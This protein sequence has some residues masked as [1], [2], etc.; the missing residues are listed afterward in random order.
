MQNSIAQD[1]S[2][3]LTNPLLQKSSLQYQAPIFDKIKDTDF[4]P[5]FAIFSISAT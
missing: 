4:K 5:A 2:V 1:K 3:K